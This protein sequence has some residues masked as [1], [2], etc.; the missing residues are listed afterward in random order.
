[1]R[2]AS[3][4][5][6]GGT[7]TATVSVTVPCFTPGTYIETARG[8]VLVEQFRVGDRV[9]TLDHGLQAIEWIGT[10]VIPQ[11]EL[12]MQANWRPVQIKKGALGAQK[13]DRDMLVSPQHRMLID[14]ENAELH[15]GARQVLA[16]A[17]ALTFLDGVSV[18]DVDSITYIHF[19]FK[20]HE[21]VMADGV[22][23]ESFQP[24][25]TS[26]AGL[27]GA[28]RAELMALFPDLEGAAEGKEVYVAARPTVRPWEAPL[29]F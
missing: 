13:P 7:D 11:E 6:E 17:K 29:L 4:D 22:W 18:A 26:L 24:G 2:L 23:T 3:S 12:A 16:L 27:D 14:N 28:Q 20:A 1:M 21:I 8:R 10:R 15:F 5:G 25:D 9:K 19:M